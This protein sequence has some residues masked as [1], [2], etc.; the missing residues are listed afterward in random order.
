ML[1]SV[2]V[3]VFPRCLAMAWLMLAC[4]C[5][6]HTDSTHSSG[7]PGTA[8]GPG[9]TE[10][11]GPELPSFGSGRE[12]V[13]T[14]DVHGVRL[15]IDPGLRHGQEESATSDGY[16]ETDLDLT[17]SPSGR[18]LGATVTRVSYH[19]PDGVVVPDPDPGESFVPGD[20]FAFVFAGRHLLNTVD[21]HTSHEVISNTY[22]CGR[23]ITPKLQDYCGA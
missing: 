13:G 11:V 19:R 14:W 17:L 8:P 21:I 15:T 6:R 7:V 23:G 22:W 16:Y 4:S 18:R 9:S 2:R 12:L 1:V 10:S 20:T 5:S 3:A